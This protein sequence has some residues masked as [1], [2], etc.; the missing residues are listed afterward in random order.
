M[1]SYIVKI[2]QPGW[3]NFSGDMGGFQFKDGVSTHPLPRVVC[4]RIAANV[5]AEIIDA[6]GENLGQGGA[7]A[8]I[9]TR[10]SLDATVGTLLERQSQE[11]KAAELLQVHQDAGKAPV[12]EFYTEAQLEGIAEAGGIEELRKLAAPWNVKHRSIP[13]LINLILKAQNTFIQTKQQRAE[14]ERAARAAALDDAMAIRMREEAEMLKK[15]RVLAADQ[16]PNAV[17]P[18]GKPVLAVDPAIQQA[19]AENSAANEAAAK[20]QD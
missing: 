10:G 14:D 5:S 19:G 1:Q 8:R 9:A 6:D 17:G 12:S 4:D 18:D 16:T 11:A 3:E 20:E 15:A 13:G 2:T 7:A